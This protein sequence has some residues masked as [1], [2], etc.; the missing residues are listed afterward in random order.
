[1]KECEIKPYIKNI[2]NDKDIQ[3]QLNNEHN[4]IF[5]KITNSKNFRKF[6]NIL[7]E[8]K[9]IS[10]LAKGRETLKK[11]NDEYGVQVA[12]IT[13]TKEKGK[14]YVFVNVKNL[15]P[16]FL[17]AKQAIQDNIDKLPKDNLD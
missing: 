9:N 10:I 14:N 13:T 3:E 16:K 15:L 12:A 5:N 11:I 17:E 2:T 1:M 7:F 4:S 8:A 6:N